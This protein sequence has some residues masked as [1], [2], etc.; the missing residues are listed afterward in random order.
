MPLPLIVPIAMIAAGVF[1]VGKG[2]KAAVDSSDADDIAKAAQG[3]VTSAEEN[4]EAG[5][6][7]CNDI[8]H[9]FGKKKIEVMDTSIKEFVKFYGK[10]KNVTLARSD[11]FEK[12][13]LGRFSEV[14]ISD[15][16]HTCS[17]VDGIA[18]GAA[19]GAGAGAI[20]AFGAYGGTM[21]LASA[22]TGVGISSLSGVAATN[23]TL[24]WLGGGTLASGGLGVA[25][26]SMVLGA[27]IAGPALL[28]FGSILGAQASKKLDQA[29]SNMEKA[30][31]YAEEVAVV[32]Q[33]LNAIVQVASLGSDLLAMLQRRLADAN[34]GLFDVLTSLGSDYSKYPEDAK[35]AVY[36]AVQMAQ[37]VKA[38]VDTPVLTEEGALV[39]GTLE[40]FQRQVT[41][42]E[43]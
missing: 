9:S 42:L 3:L 10:L 12:L 41:Y 39:D 24:A 40:S 19:G 27:M 25:G 33:K 38:V 11:E 17:L 20:T 14:T 5:R 8:L 22:G 37:L 43:R 32:L 28:I 6:T 7:S 23:A 1:G 21:M 2:I 15:L 18:S 4:L 35:N 36:V 26:G 34:E 29:R 31:T 13:S 30:E 16:Q